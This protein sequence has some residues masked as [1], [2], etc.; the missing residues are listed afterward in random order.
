MKTT[1]ARRH[2]ARAR[3]R[4]L[5]GFVWVVT[6][7][8]LGAP[9][10][11]RL[12]AQD[13]VPERLPSFEVASVRQNTSGPGRTQTL[14]QP[15]GR[16]V[17]TNA[18][19]KMLVADAFLGAQ[20][21]APSRVVGGPEWIDSARYDINAKATTEFQPSPGGPPREMLLMLRSL[22]E[23]RFKLKAHRESRELPVY[24]LVV[25]R[26]DAKL[27][28]Q[29]RQ[30]AV[31]CDALVATVRAGAP[32]P[33]RQPNE[34]PPCGAM[35]GPARIL[36]GGIPMQQFA[37]MLTI[38][39]ADANGRGDRDQGRLVIDKTGLTGRFAFTLTWTPERMPTS[40]PPPGVPPIDPNGP[41]FFT[42]LQEQLGLKLQSAKGPVEVVVI[43]SVERPTPD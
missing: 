4:S 20:P 38:A 14:V 23:E 25:A 28:P 8:A 11:M 43:D 15:G 18:P 22:L 40:A 24:E 21:L 5:A 3:I 32:P 6:G 42:A 33:A 2:E 36:S 7:F 1:K 17:T 31:D 12:H 37:T 29:L 10:A 16:L 13:Q 34:P 19:L 35:R 30:S 41:S 9:G 27:G 26:A 39:L